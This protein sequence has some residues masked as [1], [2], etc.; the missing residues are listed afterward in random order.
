MHVQNTFVYDTWFKL[1]TDGIELSKSFS[2][3]EYFYIL[4]SAVLNWNLF[5]VS[6]LYRIEEKFSEF[7]WYLHAIAYVRIDNYQSMIIRNVYL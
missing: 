4:E 3:N 7:L 5:D 6:K 2:S 1:P